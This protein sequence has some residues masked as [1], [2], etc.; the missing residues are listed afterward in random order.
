M[1]A[2]ENTEVHFR[3][4]GWAG[5][6]IRYQGETLLIDYIQNKAPLVQLRDA[7]E[8]F[9][10]VEP[11]KAIA[12]LVTHLHADHA[13]PVALEGALRSG[14]PVLRP[15]IATGTAADKALTGYAEA[16][17]SQ[18]RLNAIYVDFWQEQQIGPFRVHAVPASDGFG[19][20]QVSWVVECGSKLIFHGGD[21]IFHGSFWRVVNKFGPMDIA[22]LP[23][24][25]PMIDFPLLQP[26][27]PYEAVMN[28]EQAA[29]AAHILRAEKV[30][31]IH[32]GSLHKPPGYIE[33]SDPIGRTKTALASLNIKVLIKQPEE[34]S[35]L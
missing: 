16:A 33:T 17:F 1:I 18:S 25:G 10:A 34:W 20:P 27:S 2:M 32:Y 22:F 23:V 8:H 5:V 13:D 4:L 7:N 11:G 31:P 3:R 24:N 6:E 21:T 19:D 28:P 35:A 26:T 9:P 15:A 14:A 29:A 12:A 30:V